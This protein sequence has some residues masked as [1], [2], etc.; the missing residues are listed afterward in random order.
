MRRGR[1][2]FTGSAIEFLAQNADIENHYVAVVA[3]G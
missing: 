1:I 2:Q 3:G